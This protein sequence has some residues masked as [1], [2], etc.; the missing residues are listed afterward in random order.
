MMLKCLKTLC[1]ILLCA[2]S[3]TSYAQ[4]ND[5]YKGKTLEIIAGFSPGGGYD[6]YARALGSAIG[7]YIPSNPSIVVRNLTGA[8]SLR[9]ALY[10]ADA[11]PQDGTTIGIFDNGLM[12]A[13][14]LKPDVVKFDASK[15]SWIGS[16]AKDTQVCM[17]WKELGITSI[18]ELK[19][20]EVTIGVTGIDDIRYMSTAMMR[21]VAGSKI[22]IVPGYPG[23]TDIRLAIERHELDG[24][25]DSWQS[26]KSTKAEWVND[27]KI[28][29]LVQMVVNGHP[30]LPQVPKIIDF[31]DEKMKNAVSLLV[32]SGEAGRSFVGPPN[33]PKDRLKIL[34]EA[35]NQSIKDKDFLELTSKAHLDVEP[36]S[37]EDIE[38]LLDRVYKM[39]AQDIALAR[40]LIE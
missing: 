35:F 25:C 15:L 29:I 28:N 30:D 8:G 26:V 10:L 34:R 39:S 23:S 33:I 40:K 1:L 6:A 9:L 21:S 19:S 17:V 13:P 12:I 18:N 11:A 5:F 36:M 24:V 2:L 16:A 7:R 14:L 31:A 22:K 37:G 32:S 27:K 3:S 38:K 4:T 20:R